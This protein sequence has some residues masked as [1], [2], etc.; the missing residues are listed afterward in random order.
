[1]DLHLTTRPRTDPHIEGRNDPQIAEGEDRDLKPLWFASSAFSVL[2]ATFGPIAMAFS[3]CA[4]LRPWTVD[5][6][7]AMEVYSTNLIA[8]N[9]IQLCIATAS[10]MLLF[11]GLIGQLRYRL[12]QLASAGGFYVSSFC[13]V[14]LIVTASRVR[15]ELAVQHAWTQSYYYCLYAAIIF[16]VLASLMLL[17]WLSAR[18]QGLEQDI[19]RSTALT[20]LLLNTVVFLTFVFVGALIFSHV[21]GWEYTDSVYWA[22]VTLLTIGFGDLSPKTTLGRALLFPYAVLGITC[23]GITLASIRR[24][25]LD[26]GKLALKKRRLFKMRNEFLKRSKHTSFP[27]RDRLLIKAVFAEARGIQSRASR[28]LRWTSFIISLGAWLS[29]LF[30][31][32]AVFEKCE[33]QHQGWSYFE[34]LYVAFV[35]LTTIGYG[36]LSPSS[37]CGR[38]FF[39]LWTL[40]G[41]PVI[42]IIISNLEAPLLWLVHA[43]VDF[44]GVI[45]SSGVRGI[46]RKLGAGIAKSLGLGRDGLASD[47][48][49]QATSGGGEQWRIPTTRQEYCVAVLEEILGIV[50]H[51][52]K[53]PLRSFSVDQWVRFGELLDGWT[54]GHETKAKNSQSEPERDNSGGQSTVV[55]VAGLSGAEREGSRSMQHTITLG[56]FTS[57]SP[58]MGP[59]EEAEWFL[60]RLAA[61]LR[62]ELVEVT[63]Y[64]HEKETSKVATELCLGARVDSPHPV[65]M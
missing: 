37:S 1:M 54:V 50:H 30:G 4:M 29:L 38:S 58:L 8:V 41:V 9:I 35:S 47:S 52:N 15:D 20:S 17:T 63:Q 7:N 42:T 5:A 43:I 3:V 32:A 65:P 46:I 64:H 13:L 31:G 22:D 62:Q 16:F 40:L 59:R 56:E 36:D 55:A 23:L 25:V 10:S 34:A 48:E 11:L 61:V 39:V 45:A 2:G 12:V 21:E 24:L 27:I 33:Q 57:K 53:R 51:L 18:L 28:N 14:A 44:F 19:A 60:E 26:G 49:R 6:E